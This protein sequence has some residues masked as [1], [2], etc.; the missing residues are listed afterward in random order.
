VIWDR[1]QD[2]FRVP[3]FTVFVTL[4]WGFVVSVISLDVSASTL[5][6]PAPPVLTKADPA[7]TLAA[8]A[9]DGVFTSPGVASR[10]V[11]GA[12]QSETTTRTIPRKR[13]TDSVS[14]DRFNYAVKYAG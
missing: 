5:N 6:K 12:G 7:N 8:T 13:Q 2:D 11:R 14:D 4:D 1:S 3:F 9:G 10:R